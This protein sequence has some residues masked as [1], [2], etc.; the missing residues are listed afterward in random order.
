MLLKN[1]ARSLKLKAINDKLKRSL[2]KNSIKTNY[3]YKE[4]NV[5]IPHF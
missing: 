4:F 2:I 1:N 3:T 5:Y